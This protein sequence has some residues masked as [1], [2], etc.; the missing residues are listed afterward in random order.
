MSRAEYLAKYLSGGDENK[1]KKLIKIKHKK[2]DKRL[3]VPSNIRIL[4]L[5]FHEPPPPPPSSSTSLS[6][7]AALALV[8]SLDSAD[9]D[10][11][12]GD[13][14]SRP[15]V[16]KNVKENKGFK[17]IDDGTLVE[18]SS[19]DS[20]NNAIAKQTSQNKTTLSNQAPETIFRDSSGKIIDIKEAQRD[21]E[22]R[23]EEERRRK[24][25]IEVRSSKQQQL[26]QETRVF[27][28]SL[29][30]NFEDPVSVFQESRRIKNESE[31]I[32]MSK[33]VFNKGINPPNRFDIPAG[34]FW[35]GVDRSNGF[36]SLMLRKINEQ[37]YDKM[38]SKVDQ[39]YELDFD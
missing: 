23:K 8:S 16:V 30:K 11:I 18:P 12:Y 9:L 14:E 10:H 2:R 20:S 21:F 39:D 5:I 38:S 7:S 32:E 13:E 31:D 17:R 28:S 22:L 33:F 15:V 3:P 4:K 26:E 36:E 34:Y 19:L 27:K 6:S 35:D 1:Q 29:D 37:S 25:T 24:E